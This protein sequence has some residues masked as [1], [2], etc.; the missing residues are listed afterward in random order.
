MTPTDWKPKPPIAQNC[1]HITPSPVK[2]DI[3]CTDTSSEKQK[4]YIYNIISSLCV[5]D[6]TN[7][8]VPSET[9][10]VLPCVS[11]DK[12]GVDTTLHNDSF[13]PRINVFSFLDVNQV[14]VYQP[15]IDENTIQIFP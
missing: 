2:P 12:D 3:K 13:I 15:P 9:P 6:Y 4:I 1:H 11:Y 14:H 8:D 7:Q 10:E 5:Y